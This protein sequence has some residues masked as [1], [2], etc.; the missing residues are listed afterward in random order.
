MHDA[1]EAIPILERLPLAIES[2]AFYGLDDKEEESNAQ[3]PNFKKLLVGTKPGHLLVY[4]VRGKPGGSP[5]HIETLLERTNRSFSKKPIQQLYVSPEF[6]IIISLSDGLVSVHDIHTYQLITSMQRAKGASMFAADLEEKVSLRGDAAYALRLSV[7]VKRKLQIYFW[8]NHDFIQLH[9]DITLPEP[10]KSMAW[11]KDSI[12]FGFKR[13]FY[14]VKL[15][16]NSLLQELF[17]TGKSMEPV[18]GKIGSDQL[19]LLKDETSV[20]INSEGEV[21]NKNSFVWSD[22][23][24]AVESEEPYVLGILPKYVEIRTLH[25]K[26]LIQSIELQKPR[27]VTSWR[28]WTFIASTT[29]IWSLSK[30]PVETQIEQLLPNKEFELALQLAKSC[31]E[32]HNENRI[33]HIQKLLAFDQFC[34]FQ[35]NEALKTFATLNIDTSQIIGLFPNL[36]PSGYQKNLKYPGEVPAMKPDVLDNGLLVLI[37]YL[38]QKRNETVSIVTQQLPV[39]YPMVE[40][41]STI[42]SKRQLLQIID[43]TLLKCYLKTNDALV[44]PL[45][46]LPDNNC[47]VEEAERVLKQWNKQRELIELYRK[48]G[49]H[50]KAL[51]L[52]LQESQKV[53]KPENQENMIEYLQHLGQKHLDLIFHFSPGILKQNPIE[54]LKIFTADLAEV[55]SLPRK[56]VLD[57]L[58]GVSKKLVLAYLEHVVYECNDETPEFHN[59]LATSYKDCVLELMEEYFKSN[60]EVEQ[61][62]LDKGPVELQE[63][64]NKLLS[65]L[66]ISS[67]Y[68]AGRIL[69]EFPNNK[70]TEE[71]AILLGRLGRYEQ[72]LALYAHTLKDPLKAEE[73]CHKVYDQD[74]TANKDIFIHLLKMYLQPKS[75]TDK[76]FQFTPTM[77]LHAALRVMYEH[78]NKMEPAKALE[79][80]P[81]DVIVSNIQVFIKKVLENQTEK[82][83]KAQVLN[84]LMVS[85]SHQVHEQRI[86]HESNKCVITED[87]ACRVC[88]KKI[89]VSAFA[90]FPNDVVLH[91]FCCKD[92][93]IQPIVS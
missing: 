29:H 31:T 46:R 74:P 4:N 18:I 67:H 35:F 10:P 91:Y 77:N 17:P 60:N 76:Q 11:C 52:L 1:Y 51:N 37:E 41:N 63:T 45:L 59:R 90:R 26:R 88:R 5:S 23:P 3:I 70:L 68:E 84:S 7:A 13:D 34:R 36:L 58:Y 81:D 15:D 28:Q 78:S 89:G 75:T 72:A 48:K 85:E 61:L 71:R 47:H 43:T 33:R 64:R 93:N 30:V 9:N 66:E 65:F 39:V 27:M 80:L 14:F 38:T 44:A 42:S 87:R 83:H 56:K 12:C 49:L 21:V 32:G 16:G 6:K 92:K 25:P 82:K 54:G 55:E 24:L 53:K 40:G 2:I 20:F 8:K 57:F 73:Y 22:V 50:R 62:S 69:H 79:L 86:F 19:I